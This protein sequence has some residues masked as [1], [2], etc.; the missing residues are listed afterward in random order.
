MLRLRELLYLRSSMPAE[1]YDDRAGILVG[2]DDQV[3]D[4]AAV[5]PTHVVRGVTDRTGRP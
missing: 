2:V 1:S 3:A 4:R 5:Y